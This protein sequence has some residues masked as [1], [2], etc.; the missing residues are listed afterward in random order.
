[1]EEG[2]KDWKIDQKGIKKLFE[3]LDYMTLYVKSP[4]ELTPPIQY[5]TILSFLEGHKIQDQYTN[6]IYIPFILRKIKFQNIP[7]MI[8]CRIKI[9]KKYK[10]CTLKTINISWQS[11]RSKW[12]E[13]YS[14]GMEGNIVKIAILSKLIYKF[15][16]IPIKLQMYFM[17]LKCR[18]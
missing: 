14:H 11:E 9:N 6:I 3:F 7:L 16:T 5:Q 15:S 12:V 18:S 8:R 2:I 13:K 4:N 1:M 10:S 17:N